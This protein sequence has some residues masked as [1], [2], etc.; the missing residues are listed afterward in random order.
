ML[1]LPTDP[2]P[3]D[4][5]DLLAWPGGSIGRLKLFNN[6]TNVI[7]HLKIGKCFCMHMSAAILFF[8]IN[9]L[10]LDD[11]RLLQGK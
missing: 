5:L 4:K 10:Y 8:L 11:G 9:S 6:Q 1:T 7:L 2:P 3:L